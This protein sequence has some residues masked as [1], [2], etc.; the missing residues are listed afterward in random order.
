MTPQELAVYSLLILLV[1][2]ALA[3]WLYGRRD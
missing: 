2:S 1:V 3:A